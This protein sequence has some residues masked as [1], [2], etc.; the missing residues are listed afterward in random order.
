MGTKMYK[1]IIHI[2][3]TVPTGTPFQNRHPI[4]QHICTML[5]AKSMKDFNVLLYKVN[6]R[7]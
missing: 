6:E 2:Y 4:T 5:I 1:K 3:S 7:F